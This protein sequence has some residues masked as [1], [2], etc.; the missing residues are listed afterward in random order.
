VPVT[1]PVFEGPNVFPGKYRGISVARPGCR[2]DPNSLRDHFMGI[3]AYRRTRFVVV[4]DGDDTA[5]IRVTK[6]SEEPLFSKIVSVDV[7]AGPEECAFVHEPEADTAIPSA[8][9][10]VARDRA[11]DARAIVVQGLYEHVSFILDPRPVRI[12]VREVVP[13]SPA[14]LFD[15]A[16]RILAVTEDLPPIELVPE[17]IRVEDLARQHPASHYLLPCRGAG[18][19]ITGTDVS[20]LDERPDSRD[21]TL[22][23]C[24]RSQQIHHWFYDKDAPA[25]DICPLR[26]AD[27]EDR[28]QDLLLTK[29]CLREE[30]V[31]N[32]DGWTSVPW[33]SSLEQVREALFALAG[34]RESSW[35]PV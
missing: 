13:P 26:T 16:S 5:L 31:E 18:A 7:L 2:L 27:R 20:Y 34:Q 24:A 8:L 14:K 12:R 3:E 30:G 25:V 15:Q 6:E 1:P 11:P 32:G 10:Q 19:D 9:A 4:R 29:C 21:W 22:I 23:G 35:E 17:L 28:G 33:G